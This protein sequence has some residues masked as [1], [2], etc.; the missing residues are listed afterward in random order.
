M[1]TRDTF[2]PYIAWTEI[3]TSGISDC[4]IEGGLWSTRERGC[5]V[6]KLSAASAT[7]QH[8]RTSSGKEGVGRVLS[9]DVGGAEEK[10]LCWI[11]GE[12]RL[13]DQC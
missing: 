1:C 13:K 7:C 5:G 4:S 2:I 12:V 6:Q 9:A 3:G 11:T 8:Q 10:P